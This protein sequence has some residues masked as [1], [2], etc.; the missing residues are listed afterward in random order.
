MLVMFPSA[1]IKD[2]ALIKTNELKSIF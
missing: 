2:K 1:L